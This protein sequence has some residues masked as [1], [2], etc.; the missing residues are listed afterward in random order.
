MSSHYAA[1]AVVGAIV[2]ML[3]WGPGLM[4]APGIG[5]LRMLLLTG[6]SVFA[7]FTDDAAVAYL[8]LAVAAAV[9]AWVTWRHSKTAAVMLAFS[10]VLTVAIAL[11]LFADHVVLAFVASIV[12]IALRSGALPLHVGATHLCERAPALQTQQM[13][14]VIA[15]VFLHLRFVDHHPVAFDWAPVLIG[16]GAVS[17]LLGALLALASP[18]VRTFFGA[19]TAMHGGMLV[20]AVATAGQHHYA[21]ALFAALT[22][23]V[24]MGGLGLTVTA[25]ESRCGPVPLTGALGGRAQA[26]PRLAIAFLFFGL[27]GVGAP[28]T[29]GFLSDDLLLHALWQGSVIGS[30]VVVV[31]TALLAVGILRAWTQVFLGP[32]SLSLAADL[33]PRER[34]SALVLFATLL[35]L[36]TAPIL[37]VGPAT[38]LFGT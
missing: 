25:L 30:V 18:D 13:G 14:S 29:A 33:E 20:T 27:A 16:L 19:V 32:P 22:M 7:L 23:G 3:L 37:L 35:V 31:A 17:T 34:W 15:I 36:G 11:A 8:S 2:C 12:V 1:P 26:F 4:R 38:A 21:A 24:A 5:S 28:G 10:T 6:F 9:H